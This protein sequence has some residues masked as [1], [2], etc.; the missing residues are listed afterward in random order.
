MTAIEPEPV[1]LPIRRRH[2]FNPPE[3]LGSLRE[4][5]P[6][7]PL[8]F[9]DGTTGWLITGYS[10]VREVLTDNRFSARHELRK[11]PPGQPRPEPAAPGFFVRMDAPRHTRYRKLL[12]GQFTQRRMIQ[13]TPRIE[14]I[15]EECLD[16]LENRPRPVDLVQ[17][18][19]L[20]VPSLVI[21][22]LLGVP[23]ADREVFQRNTATMV[24][25]ASGQE[26][27]AAAS[28]EIS[29]F[30]ADLVQR[31]RRCPADDLLSGLIGA[32]DLTDAELT[33]I[34]FL[35]LVAG[36][37]TTANMLS[38]GVFALLCHPAQLAAL[39]AGPER[40]DGAVEE[41]LRY[42]T[43]MQFGMLRVVREDIDLHGYRIAAGE[44]VM[45]S[46]PAANRDPAQFPAPDALDITRNQ[47]GQLSFGHGAHF[48]L[49]HQLARIELRIAYT[50]LLRRFPELRLAV[51]PKEVPRREAMS[52]YGLHRLPVTW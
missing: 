50:A 17:H 3:E 26:R 52:I 47:P 40:A 4:R 36:H 33:S 37:E 43:I 1:A 46:L 49:G 30:L 12:I 48:C 34:A 45:L 38:L 22:E 51:P 29:R 11:L 7:S 9:P 18:F 21:S 44:A 6:I 19:A 10:V 15:T 39:K 16:A 32:G 24:D 2:V 13:L 5:A 14:A 35:L 42:L 8:R 28:A 27:V 20:P 41:L 23:Y 31:K 25:L